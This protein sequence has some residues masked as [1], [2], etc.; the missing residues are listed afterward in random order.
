MTYKEYE[1]P[2]RML[3]ELATGAPPMYTVDAVSYTVVYALSKVGTSI[4]VEYSDVNVPRP[5][6]S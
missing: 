2:I 5:L 4:N 1:E 6:T 3:P